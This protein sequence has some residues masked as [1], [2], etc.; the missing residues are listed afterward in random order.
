[1][2]LFSGFR[3]RRDDGPQAVSSAPQR[4]SD[5]RFSVS[6][7]GEQE[8][9]SIRT[10]L[11]NLAIREAGL[12]W[13]FIARLSPDEL[14]EVMG[15]ELP[16]LFEA[17]VNDHGIASLGGPAVWLPLAAG[18]RSGLLIPVSSETG[19]AYNERVLNAAFAVDQNVVSREITSLGSGSA[20]VAEF[21]R[22]ARVLPVWSLQRFAS[23]EVLP[24]RLPQE[25]VD[26][27]IAGGWD[28]VGDDCLRA[29]VPGASEGRT[30]IVILGTFNER[31]MAVMSPVAT[32]ESEQLPP[33]AEQFDLGDRSLEVVGGAVMLTETFV[34]TPSLTEEY[35]RHL[36]LTLAADA[37][38]LE[39]RL[40]PDDQF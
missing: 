20:V 15:R 7:S 5:E 19:E 36:I 17:R 14:L 34:V 12:C 8:D 6:L 3:N 16:E 37:D 32:A 10:E 23:F 1:M 27:M 28:P 35:L 25:I 18:D 29:L 24:P 21:L 40:S 26:S 39:S 30:Q 22:Q 2:G 13:L 31:R 4:E 11:A 33:W 9:P 38:A